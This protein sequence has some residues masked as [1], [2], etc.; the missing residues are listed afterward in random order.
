MSYRLFVITLAIGLGL[1]FLSAHMMIEGQAFSTYRL[2]PW[3]TSPDLGDAGA[4][5][6]ARAYRAKHA[7]VENTGRD[8]L[9][10]VARTDDEGRALEGRCTYMLSGRI[11]S[12]GWWTLRSAR[13]YP[14]IR[15][16]EDIEGSYLNS[17]STAQHV[18][19]ELRII[20]SPRP[21]PGNWL[22]SPD[23]SFALILS[24]YDAPFARNLLTTR[25]SVPS[26]TRLEC[27]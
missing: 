4:T 14:R 22:K 7:I 8:T 9:I 25:A 5:P 26:I 1:G 6:Y 11:T 3:V 20:I 21:R 18:D 13:N 27:T 24:F 12:A 15:Q 17:L 10:F 16:T 2:G 23:E 19:G